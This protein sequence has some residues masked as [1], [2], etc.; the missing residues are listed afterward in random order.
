MDSDHDDEALLLLE[1]QA[2]VEAVSE[3]LDIRLHASPQERATKRARPEVSDGQS[4]HCQSKRV[5]DWHCRFG[6][7][8]VLGTWWKSR[9]SQPSARSRRTC[10]VS[11]NQG[12]K[13]EVE[14]KDAG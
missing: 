11:G 4:E 9:H 5:L 10:A 2:E 3:T 1:A 6:S 12:I 14:T 13:C 8:C 7:L